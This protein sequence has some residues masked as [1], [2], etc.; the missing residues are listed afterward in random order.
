MAEAGFKPAISATSSQ[1]LRLGPQ[2]HLDRHT[3]YLNWLLKWYIA[4][5]HFGCDF[6]TQFQYDISLITVSS[7]SY[8][9]VL[10]MRDF[11]AG[12]LQ[13]LKK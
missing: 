13:R 9:G 10:R 12:R 3:N 11:P 4:C 2:G 6:C 7:K 8:Y 5:I 1:Y